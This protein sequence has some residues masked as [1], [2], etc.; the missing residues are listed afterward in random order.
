MID[1]IPYDKAHLDLFD[2]TDDDLK[3]YGKI[4]SDMPNPLADHG[5]CFTAKKDGQVL[6]VGGVLL[7]STHTGFGW[8]FV[9]KHAPKYGIA[10]FRAVRG[11]LEAIMRDFRVH[12]IETA[13]LAD[14]ADHHRWCK[15]MGFR[16]EGPM[17]Q[18]DDQGRDYIRFAK[19]MPVSG[20][21]A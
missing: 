7:T 17:W 9:S 12:R 6:C 11:Q 14:A 1:L 15:L 16:E 13:N 3:R 10:I 20:K 18:Y 19:L 4:S 5:I 8:T 2:A 21:G